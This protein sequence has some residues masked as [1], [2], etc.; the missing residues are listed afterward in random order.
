M[1]T[2]SAPPPLP[3]GSGDGM[4]KKHDEGGVVGGVVVEVLSKFYVLM[5]VAL[6]PWM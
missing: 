1:H 6:K 5:R 2:Y 4:R 3:A